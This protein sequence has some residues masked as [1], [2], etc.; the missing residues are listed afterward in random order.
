MFGGRTFI[1]VIS[2]HQRLERRSV[3][4]RVSEFWRYF[5]CIQFEANNLMWYP[6]AERNATMADT[7]LN[8]HVAAGLLPILV[9]VNFA[10]A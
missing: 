3:G 6:S 5:R 10:A 9:A 7:M 2:Q 8:R 1:V 4:D